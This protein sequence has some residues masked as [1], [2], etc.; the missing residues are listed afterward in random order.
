MKDELLI[1]LTSIHFISA[2]SQM[3]YNAMQSKVA[4]ATKPNA[5]E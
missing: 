5:E 3:K 1:Q 4:H 2:I